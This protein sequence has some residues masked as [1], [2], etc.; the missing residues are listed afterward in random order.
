M[1]VGRRLMFVSDD[2]DRSRLRD[3]HLPQVAGR[4]G[5]PPSERVTGPQLEPRPALPPSGGR[6]LRDCLQKGEI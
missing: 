4:R 1:M 2:D 3:Q 5:V 6:G